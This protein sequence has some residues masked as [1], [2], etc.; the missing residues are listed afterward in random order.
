MAAIYFMAI[1]G[2]SLGSYGLTLLVIFLLGDIY[3]GKEERIFEYQNAQIFYPIQYASQ[4]IAIA[5]I[6]MFAWML[7]AWGLFREPTDLL[8]ISAA[9]E[10]VTGYDMLAAAQANNT[11]G[12]YL[13]A[14][15]VAGGGGA[16]AAGSAVA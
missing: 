15:G 9:V 11:V 12:T 10:M 1:G 6:T 13:P 14:L 4:L 16:L 2:E 5:T 8:W 7:G 3:L